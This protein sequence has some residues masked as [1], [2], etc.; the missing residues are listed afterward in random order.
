LNIRAETIADTQTIADINRRAFGGLFEPQ[1]VALA[2]QHASYDPALSLVAERDGQIVGHALFLRHRM[3]LM[4]E[5]V[6]IVGLGPIAAAPEFQKQGVGGALIEAG[7]SLARER[8][9]VLS[10][11]LGHDTY[12]PRFGYRTHQHGAA[13]V[14]VTRAMLS[15]IS[16]I[17]LERRAPIDADIP[18]LIALWEY[19]EAAVDF[20]LRPGESVF[21]WHSPNRLIASEVW[22]RD[23]RVVGYTRVKETSPAAP[24]CFLAADDDAARMIAHAL[25][26]DKHDFVAL[27]LH[28]ASASALA[29]PLR[30]VVQAWSAGMA[31]PLVPGVLD[32]FTAQVGR[33]ERP[34]GR[35]VWP[36]MFEV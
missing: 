13:S 29:F 15:G 20:A 3:R 32:A 8:G 11:L 24:I 31:C 28:P 10:L 12:Y 7:H 34:A 14:E 4:G 2:R 22:L 27:P 25:L 9:C 5:E 18:A 26:S 35:V 6:A 19:E 17:T 30:P 16:S 23:D 33:G 36:V 1:I 21:D